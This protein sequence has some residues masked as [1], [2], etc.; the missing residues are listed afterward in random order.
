MTLVHVSYT[1]VFEIKSNLIL[2]VRHNN[3]HLTIT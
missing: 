3:L 2:F 1:N